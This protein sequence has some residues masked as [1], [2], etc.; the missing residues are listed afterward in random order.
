M[1]IK[2]G[3]FIFSLAFFLSSCGMDICECESES[4]KENPDEEVM[5][6]CRKKFAEMSMEEISRA[7][8]ECNE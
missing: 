5:E 3:F 4:Q 1:R 8:A 7:V 2:T 6:A